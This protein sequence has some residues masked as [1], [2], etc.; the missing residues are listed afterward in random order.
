M[1]THAMATMDR[2]ALQ[3]ILKKDQKTK[4]T[5]PLVTPPHVLDKIFHKRFQPRSVYYFTSGRKVDPNVL[6][7]LKKKKPAYKFP[8]IPQAGVPFSALQRIERNKR[9]EEEKGLSAMEK[10]S[11]R[12]RMMEHLAERV[13]VPPDKELALQKDKPFVDDQYYAMIK[14]RPIK[15]KFSLN[16]YINE[17]RE[18]LVTKLNIG[19]LQ[20][21]VYLIE[22]QHKNEKKRIA[23]QTKL[24]TDFYAS[25]KEFEA[26][27]HEDWL[28]IRRRADEM[29]TETSN[30]R[31]ELKDLMKELSQIR[32][33]LYV[34]EE[35]WRNCKLCQIFL[36]QIS[37]RSWQEQH[38]LKDK[39]GEDITDFD[40]VFNR[41]RLDAEGSVQSLNELINIFQED[42][43]SESSS[44]E[45]YF[46]DPWQVRLVFREMELQHLSS[47][48]IIESI[49]K[50]KDVMKQGLKAVQMYYDSEISAIEEQLELA[51][52]HIKQEEERATTLE[53][54]AKDLLHTDLKELVSSESTI[55]T[56]VYVEHAY[57][58]C[59]GAGDTDMTTLETIHALK[60]MHEDL[61]MKLDS[62]PF[63][64]VKEAESV[65]RARYALSL[66]KAHQARRQ[67]AVLDN[68][69]KSMKRALEKP[70]ARH[71]R[72]MMWRSKP[73]SPKVDSKAVVE[74]F[75][76]GEIEFLTHFTDY[77]NYDDEEAVK[78]FFP[79]GT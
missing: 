21:E 9:K 15:D 44:P 22:Q 37:P 27:D 77:C 38:P 72:P 43:S 57:E 68:L 8:A 29:A 6:D 41:Y 74:S 20:D 3:K 61:M 39:D 56:H 13:Y 58:E 50:P 65:V 18:I 49:R 55:L 67:V 48:L 23:M 40:D 31:L 14:G 75:S 62:L 28:M 53:E 1:S 63:E 64:I 12:T 2:N 17:V 78:L 46:T 76:Q 24:L 19:F 35:N 66:D 36:F 47:L 73:P 60:L 59:L 32:C 26:Q 42:I 70:Y 16:S 69:T 5:K 52:K 10:P 11:R 34:L 33:S 51:E 54:V 7:D 25:F 71:G 45:L 79:L 30:M 4:I